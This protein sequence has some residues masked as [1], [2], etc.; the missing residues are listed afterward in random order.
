MIAGLVAYVMVSI[1]F[2]VQLAA[3][4]DENPPMRRPRGDVAVLFAAVLWLP[5]AIAA[6]ALLA[7]DAAAARVR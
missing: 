7:I 2:A 5:M 1:A 3:I 4:E 6:L